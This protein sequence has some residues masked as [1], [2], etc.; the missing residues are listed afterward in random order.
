MEREIAK[1]L[2]EQFGSDGIDPRSGAPHPVSQVAGAYLRAAERVE[3]LE[4]ALRFYADESIWQH[5]KYEDIDT[6]ADEDRGEIARET[7]ASKSSQG[8]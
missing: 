2:L 7:L 1:G 4:T 8:K 6:M 3:Q 5:G